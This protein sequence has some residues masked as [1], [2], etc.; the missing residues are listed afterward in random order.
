VLEAARGD[1]ICSLFVF[2]HLLECQAEGI[3]E[4]LLAH[5]EHQSPHAHT[6]ANMLVSGVR[7]SLRHTQLIPRFGEYQGAVRRASERA[8]EVAGVN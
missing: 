4:L 1:P 5:A 6:S 2:L 3:P 7:K 8:Y